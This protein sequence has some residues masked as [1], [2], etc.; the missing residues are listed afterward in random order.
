MPTSATEQRE[1]EVISLLI[2]WRA[3]LS[4]ATTPNRLYG[5]CTTIGPHS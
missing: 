2:L 4:L 5:C 3:V 1:Y